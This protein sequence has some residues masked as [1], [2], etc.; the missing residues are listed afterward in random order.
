LGICWFFNLNVS[1]VLSGVTLSE[2]LRYKLIWTYNKKDLI[3]L[4]F[5]MKLIEKGGIKTF[6]KYYKKPKELID[7]LHRMVITYENAKVFLCDYKK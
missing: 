1:P 6:K 7:T 3:T 4:A 5:A 2:K